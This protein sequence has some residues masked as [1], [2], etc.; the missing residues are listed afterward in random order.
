MDQKTEQLIRELADKLGTTAEHL[1]AVLVR[2]API[3]ACVTIVVLLA[4]AVAAGCLV[5]K[6]T[7]Q[8]SETGD[9]SDTDPV[10][11]FAACILVI[12]ASCCA[13]NE[14]EGIVAGFLNPE[15]WAFKQ[16]VK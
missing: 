14:I 13:I 16:L 11:A 5:R 15:F 9:W 12:M 10:L 2:Q 1:W 3:S 6:L 8:K 4:L 7:K